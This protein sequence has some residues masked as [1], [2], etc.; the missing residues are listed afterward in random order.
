MKPNYLSAQEAAALIQDDA[1]VATG[2]FVSCGIPEAVERAIE[3][4]FL[5]T[6]SPRNLTLFYAA[7]QG[8]GQEAGLNHFGHEKLVGKVIG[9]HWGLV[10]KLQKL[11]LDNKLLA[12][13]LPQ[14]VISHMFR[15]ASCGLKG[16]VS[17]V[18]LQT[19]VDPRFEGGK[20]NEV[21]TED[22][23]EVV[24]LGGEEHL[25]Y[26]IPKI[27]V[28][29]LR[30]T[31]A[32]ED[33]NVTLEDE[34]CTLDAYS[35]A[36]AC[37]NAGGMVIV[38]V[39]EVVKRGTLDPKLVKVPGI[40]VN[41][42]VVSDQQEVCHRQTY[43]YQSNPFYSGHSVKV[44]EHEPP[45]PFDARKVIA[46]RAAM[47]MEPNSV[48][49]LGIGIP[50][51]VAL[52]LNEEGL[53]DALKLTVESGLIGGIPAGGKDFGATTNP[54]VIQDQ[55]YQFDFYDGGGLDVAFL[56]LAQCDQHGHINVSKFG[57][58]IPGCGG[59]INITQNAKKVVFCGTFTA[60]GVQ[61]DIADGHLKVVQEGR[62]KKFVEQVEQITFS[63]DYARHK[64]QP[65]VYI[66][67]RCVFELRVEGLVLTEVAPGIDLQ[68][69]ILDQMGFEPII[70]KDL[71]EMDERLFKNEKMHL[72]L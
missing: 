63:A 40:Y 54:E 4:R 55:G 49:N 12:Y 39:R 61:L 23:V 9:G 52:V 19:F 20:I 72:V 28:A 33:G 53:G 48:V 70:A 69:D 31:Y 38:Q 13:N 44:T 27:D 25:Y 3:D 46:R 26:H 60:G 30:G 41:A 36:C 35:M 7:G 29:L 2:G 45:L 59:F 11:A 5:Q 58:K 62:A 42:I 56:G 32:D 14:G 8:D 68:K 64:K 57:P 43:G 37:H 51:G 6:G 71:K 15:D 47:E 18:G 50:E 24:E 22:I 66:T 34:A 67:E 16:T 65:V 1:V 21:T 17:K 10:P